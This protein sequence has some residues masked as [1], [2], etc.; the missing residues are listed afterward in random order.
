MKKD[1]IRAAAVLAIVLVVY[2]LIALL[3]PFM[4]NGTYW[5][6]FVFS[7]VSFGVAGAALWFAFLRKG[8]ARSRFYGFPIAKLGV[9]YF[10]VQLGLGLVMMILAPLAPLWLAAIVQVMLLAAAL[11][12]LIGAEAVVEEIA[13]Q[14]KKLKANVSVMRALQ[15]KANMLVAQ[16][17]E[18]GTAKVLAKF[19]EELRYSDP[20]SNEALAYIEQ[21]LMAAVDQLQGAVTDRDWACAVELCHRATALLAER[22]RL[23]KLDK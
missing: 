8:D 1:T 3:A 5:V 7:L 17:T 23:C 12:G 18:P 10:A 21:D 6:S 16:C 2:L 13:V 9:L 11:L 22:N 19:A 20:V 15:S 4:K 14:D